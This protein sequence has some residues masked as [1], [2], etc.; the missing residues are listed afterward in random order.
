MLLAAPSGTVEVGVCRNWSAL[1]EKP[2]SLAATDLKS[3]PFSNSGDLSI[4]GSHN[5]RPRQSG[6]SD[7]VRDKAVERENPSRFLRWEASNPT[8]GCRILACNARDAI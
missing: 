6:I 2:R 8:A 1:E 5:Q 3:P 4:E 7:F